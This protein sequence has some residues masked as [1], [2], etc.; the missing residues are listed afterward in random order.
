MLF[1]IMLGERSSSIFDRRF[2]H[3]PTV[4]GVADLTPGQLRQRVAREQGPLHR[5]EADTDADRR[6]PFGEVA[7]YQEF[8]VAETTVGGLH[9]MLCGAQLL[10]GVGVDTGVGAGQIPDP[11][12]FPLQLLALL[13]SAGVGDEDLRA[14]IREGII[15]FA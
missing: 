4:G 3:D 14:L 1:T 13:S 11:R 8:I 10:L 2:G 9:T 12:R 5:R 6:P 15:E 7:G